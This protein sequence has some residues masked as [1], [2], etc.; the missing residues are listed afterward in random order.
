MKEYPYWWDTIPKSEIGPQKPEAGSQRPE[1]PNRADV[2]VVGAGYTGLSAARRLAMSGASVVVIE[3]ERVGWGASSRNG[4]QVLT[5]LKL[6]PGTLVQRYGQRRARALFDSAGRSVAHLEAVIA[7]DAIDCDYER[8][9]HIQAAWKRSHFDAFRVE[10]QLLAG[11][12]GH[13]VDLLSRSEQRA[14]IATDAYHGVLID[15][16][17]GALNPARYAEGLGRA[18]E[19][20][21]AR[22][23]TGVAVEGIDRAGARWRVVTSAGDVDARD[24]VVATDGYSDR[25]SG[26]LQR[27][28]IPIGSY[29][30]A[31]EPQP[32]ELAAALLPNRRVAFDSKNFLYYFRV[33]DDHR[34]V[35]GGRA[36]FSTPT[37]AT[38]RRAAETLRRGMTRVFPQLESAAVEYAWS[39]TVAFSRDRMPHAGQLDGM[40]VASGYCGHGIAMATWL[41]DIVGRLAA[42]GQVDD[43]MV[44]LKNPFPRIPLYSGVPWF[45][46]AVGAYYKVMDWLR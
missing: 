12:F 30:I 18:A 38:T 22:I 21:G 39:G 8:T 40:Y 46:P 7:A 33:T 36:E 31:T 37:A 29:V 42:G 45:L 4:G 25:A 23:V 13:H 27:R 44:T 1:V 10:Q 24:V 3:R 15:A 11:V 26:A 20:R 5:G 34:V 9:G 32:A 6:D 43:P 17:S 14:E 41:G 2:V 35:F 19:S 28:L 16:K